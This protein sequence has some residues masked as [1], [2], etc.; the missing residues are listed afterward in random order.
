VLPMGRMAIVAVCALMMTALPLGA[1]ADHPGT[2]SDPRSSG[3]GAAYLTVEVSPAPIVLPPSGVADVTLALEELNGVAA[4]VLSAEVT[5]QSLTG[6]P[7]GAAPLRL[8]LGFDVA[9]GSCAT[10]DV[11][12]E[13][14]TDVTAKAVREGLYRL[15][16]VLQLQTEDALGARS[17]LTRVVLVELELKVAVIVDE[18]LYP[19]IS[20]NL[21]RYEDDVMS[22]LHVEFVERTGRWS[23]PEALRA[24][25]RDLWTD[26][27]IS[28]AILVGYL[29]VARWELVR[30]PDDIERSQIPIFYED[31]DGSFADVDGNGLY[32][33][34]YWGPN[35][36]PEIWV[37]FLFPPR[38]EIPPTHLDPYGE[39]TGGG[40]L[41][42]YY[43]DPDLTGLQTTRVDPRVSFF[44]VDDAS[45]TFA[46]E[47][48]FSAVWT[49]RLRADVEE[50]YTI[51]PIVGGGLRMWIDGELRIDLGDLAAWHREERLYDV[52]LTRGWHPVRVEY[53]E[54][55]YDTDNHG[56]IRLDWCSTSVTGENL[57][58]WLEK[59]HAYHTGTLGQPER[60]LLWFDWGYGFDSG[61]LRPIREGE[62]DPLYGENL[63]VGCNYS[64]DA[65][66]YVAALEAGAEVVSV[67]SHA[68]SDYHALGPREWTPGTVSDADCFRLRPCKGGIVTLIWGC[69]AGDFGPADSGFSQL[70]ENL[71][72]NYAHTL[73][74]GLAAA[75]CTR[76]FGTS[77][78]ATF[79]AW[80]Q[81]SYLGLGM[82]AYI[83]DCYD[84]AMRERDCPQEGYDRWVDD[85]VLLGDPFITSD[86][87]PRDL[88]VTIEGGAR[89]TDERTVTLALAAT[90]AEEMRL[91]AEGGEWS[92]WMPFCA[93]AEWRLPPGSGGVAVEL[94]ARNG[95]GEALE[96]ISDAI[97]RVPGIIDL[98]GLVLAHGDGFTD[99][100]SVDLGVLTAP[101]SAAPAEMRARNEDG[102]W[103]AW[104][105]FAAHSMWTLSKGDGPK[106][107][108][109]EVRDG[110]DIQHMDVS[111][112]IILDTTCPVMTMAMDGTMGEAGWYVSPVRAI[113]TA[114]DAICGD[115]PV[116]YTLDGTTWTPYEGPLTVQDGEHQ[117]MARCRDAAGNEERSAGAHLK[118]DTTPPVLERVT[119][120]GGD[121]DVSLPRV[122][123]ELEASDAGAGVARMAVAEGRGD[124]GPWE[125]FRA[126]FDRDIEPTEGQHSLRFRV[127]DAAGNV[128]ESEAVHFVLDRTPPRVT[129]VRPARGS[130]GVPV[131]AGVA[132]LLSEWVDATAAGAD[133]IA[134]TDATG[135]AVQGTVSYNPTMSMLTFRP[136]APLVHF[137]RYNVTVSG[138]LCDAA[139][140]ILE[141]GQ[142]QWEFV[143]EGAL[144]GAPSHLKASIVKKSVTLNWTAPEEM[145]SGAFLGYRIYRATV[146]GGIAGE[147]VLLTRVPGPTYSDA[148]VEWNTTYGYTVRAMTEFGEG[149]ACAGVAVTPMEDAYVPPPIPDDVD[150]HAGGGP[151]LALVIVALGIAVLVASAMV[152]RHRRR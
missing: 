57:N 123:V 13:L 87:H 101:G 85:E 6:A 23:T 116:E 113:I 73:G 135:A 14:P 146:T 28:G 141:G 152:L 5:F 77:F 20:E 49:G 133:A 72:V 76:S 95:Y 46:T 8:D 118:I 98:T 111:D 59:A 138:L 63:V 91:R 35:D 25:I 105:P 128:A 144:P 18:P 17:T 61:M 37:S 64:Y 12:L 55:S 148:T 16:A 81:R 51:V 48:D 10:A 9:G 120:N 2:G 44:W 70:S 68:S 82:L 127:E 32:D 142:V 11:R 3:T 65:L 60:G 96:T 50:M 117:L 80:Q 90:G 97:C 99:R 27:G 69:H 92:A 74:Y 47:H 134:L 151:S 124:W 31:L 43:N 54:N 94:Q 110:V 107:V 42:S 104:A 119:V 41:G 88:D 143:T 29:P 147:P 38:E 67:F 7:L 132:V 89:Y 109:V 140:N 108:T 78:E 130:T 4:R 103:G 126:S 36:G 102:Q 145:G 84:S 75:G 22:N 93:T 139:G 71:C 150:V 125:P 66:D 34:H 79:T 115:V 58:E 122:H 39:G 24:F 53:T 30:A 86:H 19:Y 112:E 149:P 114:V 15:S 137:D 83:D 131:D 26:E 33:H 100:A 129:E 45:G 52:H 1:C 121:G 62:F 56:I 21:T 106:T 40:L 136:S